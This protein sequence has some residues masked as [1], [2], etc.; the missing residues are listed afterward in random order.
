MNRTRDIR[1]SL[2]AAAALLLAGVP[3]RA[4]GLATQFGKVFVDNVPVGST[5]S[6]QGF[7]GIVYRIT[8]T[9]LNKEDVLV[10]VLKPDPGEGNLTE[11]Y[12]AIP[13]SRWVQLT[14]TEFPKLEIS[15]SILGAASKMGFQNENELIRQLRPGIDVLRGSELY[16]R[17]RHGQSHEADRAK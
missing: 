12:E 6:L 5:V 1:R 8:N 2:W 13:D 15:V 10:S 7:S 3:A 4:G 14:K 16:G 17:R 9:S 11:G